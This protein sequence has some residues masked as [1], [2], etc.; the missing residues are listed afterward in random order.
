VQRRNYPTSVFSEAADGAQWAAEYI[1]K[2][3]GQSTSETV[4][5]IV[6]TI[7]SLRRLSP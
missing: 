2:A 7:D 5:A 3:P 6:K 1:V 4:Q